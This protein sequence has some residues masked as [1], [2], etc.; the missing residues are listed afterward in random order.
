MEIQNTK[1]PFQEEALKKFIHRILQEVR[2]TED[3]KE[4]QFYK[5][6][7]RK[8]VSIFLR[9]YF[10]AYLLKLLYQVHMEGVNLGLKNSEKV[11]MTALFFSMGKNRKVFPRDLSALICQLPGFDKG[12]IGEIKILDNYSFVEVT[13]SKAPRLIEALNGIDFKGK[14]LT[15]NYARKKDEASKNGALSNDHTDKAERE[16]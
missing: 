14:K 2:S 5:K 7:I 8:Q 13:S 9:S 16:E 3:P 15:V 6:Q 11:P 10:S 12:D 1:L 4:L